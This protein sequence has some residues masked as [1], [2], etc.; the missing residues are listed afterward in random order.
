MGWRVRGY[1]H[2]FFGVLVLGG[3]RIVFVGILAGAVS[4][5]LTLAFVR[6]C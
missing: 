2:V 3:V 4:T 1:A 6:Y 5:G